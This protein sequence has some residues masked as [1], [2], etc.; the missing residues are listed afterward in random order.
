M[1]FGKLYYFN[2]YGFLIKLL[3]L[4][5]FCFFFVSCN[6]KETQQILTAEKKVKVV[7]N[8]V[9]IVAFHIFY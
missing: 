8:A 4:L 2:I 7:E 3:A 1:N 9:N 6:K 5:V